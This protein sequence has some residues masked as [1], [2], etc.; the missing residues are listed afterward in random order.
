MKK[1]V[2]YYG[3]RDLN[4]LKWVAKVV[5][6]G[7][8]LIVTSAINEMYNA[9]SFLSE[10]KDIFN[11]KV[12]QVCNNAFREA[13]RTE[14]QIKENMRHEKFWEDYSDTVIDEAASD[15]TLFR[16]SIKQTLDNAGV[17]DSEMIS[18]VETTRVM[19]ELAVGE[20]DTIM[21]QAKDKFG[22]NYA[23]EFSE[24]RMGKAFYWWQKMCEILYKGEKANLNNDNTQVM[25]DRMC[26][27]FAEGEYIQA[28]LEEANR[29]NP[30]FLENE[31]EVHDE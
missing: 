30:D 22:R 7:V 12:K 23:K 27:K 26:R 21:V 15:M 11:G 29:N 19:L 1:K 24:Y 25:F 4:G 31:I 17:R 2:Y 28:C 14:F 10:R 5:D 9:Y 20:Y 6:F 16:I 18:Y 13:R 8:G 3:E